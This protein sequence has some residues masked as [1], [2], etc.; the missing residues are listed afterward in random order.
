MFVYNLLL[1]VFLRTTHYLLNCPISRN[2]TG[3]NVEIVRPDIL[4]EVRIPTPPLCVCE[5][6]MTL[7]FLLRPKIV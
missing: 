7:P 4:T 5:F 6:M 1:F 3:K 2:S